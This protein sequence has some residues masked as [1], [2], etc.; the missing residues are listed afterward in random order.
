MGHAIQA[1]IVAPGVPIPDP[2]P[3]HLRTVPLPQGFT[4]LPLT[5][6]LF[7]E[8]RVLH[9]AEEREPCP[10]FWKFSASLRCFLVNLSRGGAVAYIET[11]YF[12]GV[13]EQAAA[14]WRAGSPVFPPSKAEVG[15]IN[16]ALRSIGA[17]VERARDEFE[18]LGLG[19]FEE[20]RGASC[21][22]CA[23]RL[24]SR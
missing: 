19:A 8:L 9:P 10:A 1:I 3:S 5:G 18:A 14:S 4:L 15:P 21:S 22:R 20:S 24:T 7:D 2:Q 16:E 23:S 6:D 13:G 12:G 17:Q 11:D